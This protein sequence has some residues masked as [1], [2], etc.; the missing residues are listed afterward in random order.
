MRRRTRMSPRDIIWRGLLATLLLVCC[1]SQQPGSSITPAYVDSYA[2]FWWT[3]HQHARANA[4]LRGHPGN[5]GMDGPPLLHVLGA[6]TRLG[7][8]YYALSR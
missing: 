2:P 6:S 4:T 5:P 8:C 3:K 7:S 1:A